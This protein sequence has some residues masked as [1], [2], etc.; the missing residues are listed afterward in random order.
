MRKIYFYKTAL[1]LLFFSV[2]VSCGNKEKGEENAGGK[3]YGKT[4]IETGELAAVNSKAF[5]LQRYGRYWYEMKVIGI[6]EHGAIVSEGDSVMQL[7]PT[8]IKKYI[9]D[10]ES[11]LET[12]LATL[13]KMYVDQD[14]K[15]NELES[16]EKSEKASFD[17]KKIELESSRFEPEKTKEIKELEFRQAEITLT[18]EQKKR[19]LLDIINSND[20]KIQEIKVA[21]VRNE[22]QSAYDIIPA[23]TI[24]TPIAGV[25]QIAR[26]RRTNALVKVGDNLYT[27]NNLANVPE[28]KWMKVNTQV[29]ETDFLKLKAGQ[30]VNVRLDALPKVVFEGKVAY[31]GKLCHRK[32]EKS[33]QK[34]FDV[35]VNILKPDERLKP[36]M[37]V[38]CEF[39]GSDK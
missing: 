34:V 3:S 22:I 27:G 9:I 10:R 28:L 33:K 23:L 38:S 5:V 7:D 20:I 8:D 19:K 31:I 16:Q 35:E 37:T 17:L 24:R 25:F 32:D 26:N 4:V 21:Q 6:I 14:N 11:Q 36:G 15:R 29:N 30:K 2:F 1:L 39:V 12:E 18:K 13:Q